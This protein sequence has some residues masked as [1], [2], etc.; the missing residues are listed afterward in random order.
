M[1]AEAP[2]KI[3]KEMTHEIFSRILWF[4]RGLYHAAAIV[5]LIVIYLIF[6]NS[7]NSLNELDAQETL[8]CVSFISFVISSG[9]RFLFNR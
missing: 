8:L 2:Q 1:N 5:G 4:T 9:V 6:T 7:F 3:E